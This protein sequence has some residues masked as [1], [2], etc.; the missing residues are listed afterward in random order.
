MFRL[1]PW[2]AGVPARVIKDDRRRKPTVRSNRAIYYDCILLIRYAEYQ[3]KVYDN[4]SVVI[5]AYNEEKGIAEIARP[6]P[7]DARQPGKGGG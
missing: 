7:G 3:E 5:P 6:G 1:I 2:L 4:L